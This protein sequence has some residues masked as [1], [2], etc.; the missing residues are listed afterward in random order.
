M[1]A[2]R[3]LA[4]QPSDYLAEGGTWPEGPLI[5]DAPDVAVFV[6]EIARRLKA[7]CEATSQRS[8]AADAEIDSKTVNNIIK[9]TSWGAV[10]TIF[11]LEEALKKDLWPNRRDTSRRRLAPSKAQWWKQPQPPRH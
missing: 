9:G 10:P 1:P 2:R 6:M 4:P 7:A 8:V 5:G 11:Q 3:S